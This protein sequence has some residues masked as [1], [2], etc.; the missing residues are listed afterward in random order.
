MLTNPFSMPLPGALRVR[1]LYPLIDGDGSCS[2][3]YDLERAAVL[4]VPEELQFHV[5]PALETGDLDEALVDWMVGEDLLT[6]DGRAGTGED[7]DGGGSTLATGASWWHLGAIV[8]RDGEVHARIDQACGPMVGEAMDFVFKQSLGAT[9]VTFHLGW[10]GSL[11]DGALLS[12]LVVEARRRAAAQAQEVRFELSLDAAAVTP[13]AVALLADLPVHVRLH[14]GSFPGVDEEARVRESRAWAAA[15]SAVRQ[16]RPIGERITVQVILAGCARLLDLWAWAKKAGVRHLDA[17]R[18]E[19][20]AAAQTRVGEVRVF[21]GDLQAVFQE[22]VADLE[23]GRLPIDFE[24]L[25][26]VVRRLMRRGAASRLNGLSGPAGLSGLHGLNGLNGL[27]GG[28]RSLGDIY[29]SGPEDLEAG[30]LGESRAASQGDEGDEGEEP[31][32]PPCRG[33]WARHACTRSCLSTAPLDA[34]DRREP[35]EE[36][37]ALW[38]TEAEV[39]LRFYHRLS[40]IDPLQVMTLFEEAARVPVDPFDRPFP[41][42]HQTSAF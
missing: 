36:R 15:E 21:R 31:S 2:L 29:L 9:C 16:L 8:R 41:V 19:G 7:W 28:L 23:A 14:C 24:P 10:A 34:W 18:M 42:W 32:G 12:G 26:R 11:P 33:C 17:L 20:P 5:A 35:S 27:N 37:C 13:A 4:D 3:I 39:A 40:Q 25:T 6:C 30:L 38:R 1:A 22:M